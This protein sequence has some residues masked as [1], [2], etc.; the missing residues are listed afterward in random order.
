MKAIAAFA[1]VMMLAPGAAFAV[2]RVAPPTGAALQ[3][4]IDALRQQVAALQK[5]VSALQASRTN[6]VCIAIRCA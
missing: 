4:Q 1:V 3:A 5:Q 2:E 6:S